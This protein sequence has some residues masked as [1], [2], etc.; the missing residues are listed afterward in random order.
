MC[1]EKAGRAAETGQQGLD[2]QL[3]EVEVSLQ[4]ALDPYSAT[5][6]F[7]TWGAEE[8]GVEEAETALGLTTMLL[9]EVGA[10]E[11]R[12][13]EALSRVQREMGLSRRGDEPPS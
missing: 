9:R 7:L 1:Q 5:K 2:L 3:A 4:A 10:D 13:R 6:I 12:V 8:I 11:E